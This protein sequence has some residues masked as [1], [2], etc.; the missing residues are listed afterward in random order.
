MRNK[1]GRLYSYVSTILLIG[2]LCAAALL[3]L[4]LGV[5]SFQAESKDYVSPLIRPHFS[6]SLS[7]LLRGEPTAIINL[8]ILMMMLTPFFRVVTAAFSFF[9]EKDFKYAAVALGVTAILLFTILP[10]II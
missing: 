4:G 7:N 2:S 3:I 10:S 5:L 8:G 1:E 6:V 9:W